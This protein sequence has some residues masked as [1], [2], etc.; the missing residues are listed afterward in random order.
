MAPKFHF[1]FPVY[2]DL[3]KP[4]GGVK[5]IHRVAEQLILLGHQVTLVQDS[6]AFRPSWFQSSINTISRDVWFTLKDLDPNVNFVVLAETFLPVFKSYFP[7]LKKIIFNQ[8]CAYTFGLPTSN[9]LWKPSSVIRAYSSPSI[10][11]IWCVSRNDYSFLTQCLHLPSDKVS[12][13]VNGI[14]S[15]ISVPLKAKKNFQIAYMPRK[16]SRD[17]KIVRNLIECQ[18]WA[19]G[20]SFVL[21]ENMTHD[22]TI[23]ILQESL[24]FLSFGHPEGFGLPV[25]EALACGCCV[26]G[27]SGLGGRELFNI[28]PDSHITH[29]VEYGDWKGFVDGVMNAIHVIKEDPSLHVACSLQVSA[30]IREKYGTDSFRWSIEQALES[31]DSLNQ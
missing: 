2:P 14:E 26:I 5:Q 4:I 29:Q 8:N 19:K 6:I 24:I 9:H 22:Q 31:L 13:L 16:N 20:W 1:W 27:Y 7:S 10:I 11:Q 21:I 18:P 17:S 23:H 15:H 28:Q 25:A 3:S 12:L 30:S